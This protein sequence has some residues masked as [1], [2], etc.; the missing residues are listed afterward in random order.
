MLQVSKL[1]TISRTMAN[2]TKEHRNIL[3]RWTD[4]QIWQQIVYAF[5]QSEG[6]DLKLSGPD[7]PKVL[8]YYIHVV[9]AT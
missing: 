4:C 2:I 8:Q 6:F 7:K 5:H 9:A 3:D 1:S